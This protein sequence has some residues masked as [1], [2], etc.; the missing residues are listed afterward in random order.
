MWSSFSVSARDSDVSCL[1]LELLEKG[2]EAHRWIRRAAL[3][4]DGDAHLVQLLGGNDLVGVERHAARDDDLLVIVRAI[5][6]ANVGD[7]DV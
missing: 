5:E 1:L 4:N 2:R 6:A 7:V 3:T